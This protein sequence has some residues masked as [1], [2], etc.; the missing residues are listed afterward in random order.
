MDNQ[1]LKNYKEQNQG[2]FNALVIVLTVFL[3]SLII[4]VGVNIQNKMKERQY[5]GLD[6]ES[7]N[8]ITVSGRGEVYGKP[9]LAITS[10]SVVTEKETPGE[11]LDENAKKMNA[12]IDF[13]KEQGIEDKD[14]KTIGFAINPRY[15]WHETSA[16][17]Q[18]KRVLVGY[19]VNQSLEVKI[20]DMEKIGEIIEGA[21]D[22]GANEVGNLQ[23]TIDKKEELEKQARNQA[24]E[25]AK[26]EAKELAAQLGVDLVRISGFNEIGVTPIYE[27][28][29]A[30]DIEESLRKMEALAPEIEIGENKIEVNVTIVYEIR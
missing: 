4:L 19:E 9:D 7:Q 24:I 20:R 5:I 26:N 14:L 25:E 28:R 22:I 17:P 2:L 8:T 13:M 30:Y 6:I 3:I 18:G 16:Y 10:F 27:R 1:K 11:A 15:E 29:R 23:F 12:V 21:T